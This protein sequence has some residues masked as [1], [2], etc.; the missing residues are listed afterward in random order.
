MLLRVGP[1]LLA[2]R[3]SGRTLA[4]ITGFL[5]LSDIPLGTTLGIYTLIV[6]LPTTAMQLDDRSGGWGS[7]TGSTAAAL[8][9]DFAMRGFAISRS[10]SRKIS[11]SDSFFSSSFSGIKPSCHAPKSKNGQFRPVF[12]NLPLQGKVGSVTRFGR[13]I[14]T[15]RSVRATSYL[16]LLLMLLST[17]A[18]FCLPAGRSQQQSCT[19]YSLENAGAVMHTIFLSGFPPNL[20]TT[21]R[22]KF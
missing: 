1:A 10:T 5:S 6:L 17:L 3:R 13:E 12:Q 9:A 16:F 15:G 7:R 18:T 4:L 19:V 22:C 2:G 20:V 14:K 21:E 8:R 11:S